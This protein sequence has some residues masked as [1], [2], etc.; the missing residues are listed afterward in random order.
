MGINYLRVN[1]LFSS[2]TDMYVFL[3]RSDPLI[4]PI[5][6]TNV[7]IL[8]YRGLCCFLAHACFTPLITAS[9]N[10]LKW[11]RFAVSLY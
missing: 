11:Y 5:L 3:C 4:E 2:I 9:M 7:L 1:D 6:H 10:S 8:R